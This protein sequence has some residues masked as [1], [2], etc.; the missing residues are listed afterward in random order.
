[1]SP[2]P[3]ISASIALVEL[4]PAEFPG[5][6]ANTVEVQ[7]FNP[8]AAGGASVWVAFANVMSTPAAV[9][10]QFNVNNPPFVGDTLTFGASVLTAAGGP[11]VPGSDTFSVDIR[12]EAEITVLASPIPVGQTISVVTQFGPP[13]RATNLTAVTAPRV[14]GSNTFESTVGNNAQAAAIAAALNDCVLTG[15]TIRSAS[16]AGP[17]VTLIAGNSVQKRGA[18]GNTS[19]LARG[20]LFGLDLETSTPDVA[21]TAFTGG[22]NADYPFT[23]DGGQVQYNGTLSYM[24]NVA[25]AIIDGSNAALNL[26]VNGA[27]IIPT[28]AFLRVFAAP[29][30]A[31]GNGIAVVS[32]NPGSIAVAA[33]PTAGG[34]TRPAAL[35]ATNAI[36][37]APQQRVVLPVGREGERNPVQPSSFWTILPGSN[38]GLIGQVATGGAPTSLNVIYVNAV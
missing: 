22:V 26:V 11:Y 32:S 19:A 35:S 28:T 17:V 16:A 27:A 21:V 20:T 3:A 23:Q 18:Q 29:I 6:F 15:P 7:L 37:V 13:R 2:L 4:I 8:N 10:L 9:T 31:A 24:E 34:V 14:P 38:I 1:M 33:S 36:I 12:A 5:L 25:R 30:G